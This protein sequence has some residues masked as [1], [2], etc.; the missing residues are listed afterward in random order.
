[1]NGLE[2]FHGLPIMSV[3]VEPAKV[4]FLN[5]AIN[6]GVFTPLGTVEA[7]EYGRSILF[8]IESNPGPGAGMLLAYI[9]FNKGENRRNAIGALPIHLFGGIH[10]IYF[11]FVILMPVLIIPLIIAG[12]SGVAVEQILGGGLRAPASPGSIIME[13]IMTPNN[14]GGYPRLPGTVIN[15]YP[16]SIYIANTAGMLTGTA[17]SFAGALICFKFKKPNKS[18]QE[19]QATVASLKAQSKNFGIS[20]HL[21]G[22]DTIVF[23]CDAGMGSSAMGATKLKKILV[24]HGINGIDVIH[25]SVSEIPQNAKLIIVHQTLKEQVSRR[26]ANA[27]IITIKDFMN[28]PEYEI[29]AQELKNI[30]SNKPLVT[31]DLSK[32]ILSKECIKLNCP[33][34]TVSQAIKRVGNIL[35]NHGAVA[36]A[37]IT[38]MIKRDKDVSVAIGNAIAIPHAA[39][40]DR[41]YIK[42][43]SLA[44]TTYQKPID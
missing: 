7:N 21:T 22:L 6:H 16:G 34:E 33:N 25:R 10:E 29:L 35:F 8:M 38:G 31:N 9:L 24:Q 37:Y 1:V 30:P 41:K 14:L 15:Y 4:L 18:L 2:K 44:I 3:I 11:P 28:A 23:A 36:Q 27:R 20:N 42:H 43:N 26:N 12:A 32:N 39:N 13:Y 40:Q 5:N 17:I 19:S